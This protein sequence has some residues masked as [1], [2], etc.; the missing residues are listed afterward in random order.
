MRRTRRRHHTSRRRKDHT[1]PPPHAAN[2]ATD[3][4]PQTLPPGLAIVCCD[5]D[6]M[7][8]LFADL[9]ITRAAADEDESLILGE[10]YEEVSGLVKRV[11]AMAS[12]LGDSRVLCILDQNLDGYGADD[13]WVLLEP[14]A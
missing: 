3:V 7:P 8:R 1:P 6:E 5:D 14:I 9:L 4:A 10:T 12:R 13:R 11:L 2:G